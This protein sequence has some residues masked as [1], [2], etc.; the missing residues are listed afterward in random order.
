MLLL[1]VPYVFLSQ[2]SS[3]KSVE[4]LKQGHL[5]TG[6]NIKSKSITFFHLMLKNCLFFDRSLDFRQAKG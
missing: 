5:R 2:T 3:V 4:S 6:L 1:L